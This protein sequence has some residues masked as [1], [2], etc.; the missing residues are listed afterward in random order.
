VY[1]SATLIQLQSF[2]Q[3]Q[4]WTNEGETMAAKH[5]WWC[6]SRTYPLICKYCGSKIFHLSCDC[7]SSVLFDELGWPW[8]RHQ[9]AG[10]ASKLTLSRLGQE[11]LSGSVLSYIAK[12]Q[13]DAI[14]QLIE[15]RIDREYGVAIQK[16]A[17]TDKQCAN[18]SSWIIKQD[19]YHD[20]RSTECGIIMELLLNADIFKKANLAAG[21]IGIAMLGKFAEENLAQITIHTGALA[22][23]A[24]ENCSFT[25][26][27]SEKVVKT[28]KL[29]KGSLVTAK[30]RGI[31]V[32]SRF[33]V[34]VCDQLFDLC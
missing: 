15:R 34:W 26:F 28:L 22:E 19:P 9:C 33:P 25:F 1:C 5:G 24:M 14:A 4:R 8:P 17:T 30:L 3:R 2:I 7:G 12:D 6:N 10:H 23:D 27:V 21:S 20:A 29:T 32:S 31:A 11:D 13:A 16:A 18:Y